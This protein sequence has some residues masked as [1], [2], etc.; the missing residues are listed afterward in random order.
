MASNPATT[1]QSAWGFDLGC[2]CMVRTETPS[3]VVGKRQHSTAMSQHPLLEGNIMSEQLKELDEDIAR[4]MADILGSQCGAALAI[5]ELEK[6]RA[7]GEKAW[8]ISKIGMWLVGSKPKN[9]K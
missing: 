9:E 6:R 8:L 2:C 5:V 1:I 3:Q 7:N 4:R